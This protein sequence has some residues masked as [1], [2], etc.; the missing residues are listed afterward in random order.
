VAVGSLISG[1]VWDQ[2]GAGVLFVFASCCT[3]L[4]MAIVWRFIQSPVES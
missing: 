2:W 4:A 1:L 3:L